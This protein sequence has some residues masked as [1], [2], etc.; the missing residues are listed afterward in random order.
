MVSGDGK[1]I[2]S[3]NEGVEGATRISEI[4]KNSTID[5]FGGRIDS[6][7]GEFIDTGRYTSPAGTH[8]GA[9][10]LPPRT[11]NGIFKQ[12]EVLKGIPAEAGEATAWFG[13]SGGGLQY[14]SQ[15]NIEQLLKDGYLRPI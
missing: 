15:L 7:S 14:K 10:A 1:W 6:R 2:Y 11:N 8:Y 12:Y 9:R 5:R 13:E 3:P 4:P